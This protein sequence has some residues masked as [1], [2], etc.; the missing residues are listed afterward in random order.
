MRQKNLPH[1]PEVAG[2]N[3]VSASEKGIQEKN[4][5]SFFMPCDRRVPG[6]AAPTA[7]GGRRRKVLQARNREF[8]RQNAERESGRPDFEV[9]K[10]GSNPVSASEKGIQ[11]KNLVSFFMPCD[12]RVFTDLG[13]GKKKINRDDWRPAHLQYEGYYQAGQHQGA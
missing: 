7:A 11:E 12:R 1:N 9:G 3:P 13:I 2:S 8:R 5:V 4:L 6:A 10:A